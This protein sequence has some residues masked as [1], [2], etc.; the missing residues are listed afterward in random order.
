MHLD[1]GVIMSD[2]KMAL[3]FVSKSKNEGFARVSVAAFVA[4]LDPTMDEI[5]DVKTAVSEAVT[6]AIIHGYDGQEDGIVRIEAEIY[7]NEVTIVISDKGNGIEDIEQ[8]ME[9]LYTSRPDLERSG[10]GFTVMDTFMD[11]LR[12]ESEKGAGTRVIIKKKFSTVS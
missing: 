6:N 3:E 12:V 5:S 11:Y 9:P 7:D 1:G 10:M 4:Q 8:A 2:N